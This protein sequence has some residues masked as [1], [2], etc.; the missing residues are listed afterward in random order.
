M[1][2]FDKARIWRP[3]W[4]FSSEPWRQAPNK[5]EDQS[6]H[7]ASPR[8]EMGGGE[9]KATAR[10]C[11]ALPGAAGRQRSLCSLLGVTSPAA[12]RLRFGRAPPPPRRPGGP[13]G[14][15]GSAAL[16]APFKAGGGIPGAGVRR[17]GRRRGR[18][19]AGRIPP[20]GYLAPHLAPSP[21]SGRGAK[22]PRRRAPGRQPRRRRGRRR[23][24]RQR[25]EGAV[26][27]GGGGERWHRA[28]GVFSWRFPAERGLVR[29]RA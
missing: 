29:A 3:D 17:P 24:R 25:R 8:S 11:W 5:C 1:I 18:F 9:K 20:R 22:M 15:L 19:A 7:L 4:G 12:P 16:W 26:G 21:G 13:P 6:G 23:R 28:E 10:P 27:G 2:R 14:A